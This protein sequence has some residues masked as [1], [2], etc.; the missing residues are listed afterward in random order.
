MG[1]GLEAQEDAVSNTRLTGT[2]TG[3]ISRILFVSSNWS[4]LLRG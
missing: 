3:T 2:E 1:P 4:D